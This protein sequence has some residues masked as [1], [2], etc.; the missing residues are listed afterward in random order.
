M[1]VLKRVVPA[2]VAGNVAASFRDRRWQE[3]LTGALRQ[4]LSEHMPR[5]N[6]ACRRACQRNEGG[7]AWPS[8]ATAADRRLRQQTSVRSGRH[9]ITTAQFGRGKIQQ[10]NLRRFPDPRTMCAPPRRASGPSSGRACAT[11]EAERAVQRGVRPHGRDRDRPRGWAFRQRKSEF[12]ADRC[13]RPIHVLM[14]G[15]G[16]PQPDVARRRPADR[17]G[18]GRSSSRGARPGAGVRKRTLPPAGGRESRPAA[19]GELAA[20]LLPPQHGR[21]LRHRRCAS[22]GDHG[23]PRHSGRT[24]GLPR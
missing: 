12:L 14:V 18:R 1:S 23:D 2:G 4:G 22:T 3:T 11:P 21:R 20:S 6:A 24:R 13:V 16:N 19:G 9:Q 7:D 8:P 5:S 10:A 15:R 17:R